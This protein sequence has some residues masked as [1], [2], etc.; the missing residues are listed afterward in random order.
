MSAGDFV[1]RLGYDLATGRELRCLLQ[2]K[3]RRR[4]VGRL[5]PSRNP[6]Y[7]H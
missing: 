1:A 5:T 3:S 6:L 4:E 7:N 2:A